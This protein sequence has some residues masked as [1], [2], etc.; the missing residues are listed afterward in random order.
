MNNSR[1]PVFTPSLESKSSDVFLTDLLKNKFIKNK[2]I[3][4]VLVIY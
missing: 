4:I 3:D 2:S 1:R